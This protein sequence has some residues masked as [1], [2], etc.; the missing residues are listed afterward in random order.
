MEI[1]VAIKK[2][3][4]KAGIPE[5]YAAKVKAL[6]NIESEENLESY[7]S[8]FKDNILP[9][10]E[11]TEQ[12]KKTVADAAIAEYEKQ[13]GLKDGK[14]VDGKGK[15]G[16]KNKTA[17]DDDD[18]DV[19]DDL[20]DL[21][22]AFKKMLQAQQKQIQ[23][24]TDNIS[25]LTKTVSDSGKNASAKTLFD[26]AKLPEKWFKRID[27]N[28]ETSVEDQ[29]KELQ[30]EYKEIRQSAISDEVDAGNYRPYVSQPKDRTEKEWLDIMNKEEGA[31]DSNGVA[32][33][34]ID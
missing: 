23:A 6:F 11:T 17:V 9:D 21:S 32:S 12:N 31:G 10:L 7:I 30:E 1:L 18:D 22:P 24:L 27:V 16:K 29:I 8:L 28:S 4:K 14:P 15:K 5:K 20:D 26:A 3:L 2:A 33:L 13:H 25:T 19:D 34:G